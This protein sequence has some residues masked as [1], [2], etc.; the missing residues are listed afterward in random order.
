[1]SNFYLLFA[2]DKPDVLSLREQLRASHRAYLNDPAPHAVRVILGGPTLTQD[3]RQM[4]GTLLVIQAQ[5]LEEVDAFLAEDPY[6]KSGVF[7]SFEVRPWN[8]SRGLSI[9]ELTI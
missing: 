3:S 1:M 8:W 6:M 9:C 5:T 4:N 7:A 2:T